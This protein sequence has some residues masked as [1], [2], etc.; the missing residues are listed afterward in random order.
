VV[1]DPDCRDG[2]LLVHALHAGRHAIGLAR[3]A[4][5]WKTARAHVTTAKHNGAWPDATILD[6]GRRATWPIEL[7]NARGGVD[8]IATAIRPHHPTGRADPPAD[9]A[10]WVPALLRPGG[11]LIIAAPARSCP[12][13][14]LGSAALVALRCGLLLVERDRVTTDTAGAWDVLTLRSAPAAQSTPSQIPFIAA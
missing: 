11:H 8:L 14:D 13:N 7:A 12:P 9:L 3:G 1:L 2:T 10:T 6:I 4:H 5:W